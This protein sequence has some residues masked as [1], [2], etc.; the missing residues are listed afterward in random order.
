MKTHGAFQ[1]S[2]RVHGLRVTPGRVALLEVLG[3]SGKPMGVEDI[4]KK[5]KGVLDKVNVYRALHAL[6]TIGLVKKIDL[7]YSY[8][9]Y[10]IV[11][12]S[13][14]HHHVVCEK[15]GTI[16]DIENCDTQRIEADALKKSKRFNSIK[17]HALEFFGTCNR[18]AI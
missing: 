15:C 12:D 1:T 13:H 7:Q 16:E 6:V 18:C 5:L 14:H 2:L 11:N 4:V 3:K 10:E 17:T 9:H 8:T